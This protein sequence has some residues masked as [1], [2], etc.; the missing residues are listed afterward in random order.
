MGCSYP[1]KTL[2]EKDLK[3]EFE[4]NNMIASSKE[5]K[6]KKD[7]LFILHQKIEKFIKLNPFYEKTSSEFEEKLNTIKNNNR[8]EI[9]NLIISTFFSEEKSYVK[10]LFIKAMEYALKN[11][12]LG[13][14]VENNNN[15]YIILIITFIYIFLTDNKQGKIDL[16]RKNILIIFKIKNENKAEIN[17]KYKKEDIFNLIIN[18]IHMHTFFFKIFF[19]YFSF[20]EIFIDDNSNYEKIINEDS[21][22]NKINS[23]I[24]SYLN[25]IN[26]NISC[27]FLNFLFVSEINN[28]I[29]SYFDTEN[30]DELTIFDENKI[31]NISDIIYQTININNFISF[32]FFGDNHIY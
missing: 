14:N 3:F 24:E 29:K 30:E 21:S 31:N 23:F 8:N 16:F 32:I 6:K 15:D 11:Y 10:T 12:D 25:K 28:K 22:I 18:I 7:I 19:L 26:E 9:I 27:D 13:L 17:N 5:D 20:S 2:E 1:P 4:E